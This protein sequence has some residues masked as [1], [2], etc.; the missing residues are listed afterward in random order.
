VGEKRSR[1]F[2]FQNPINKKAHLL[3]QMSFFVNG[4]TDVLIIGPVVIHARYG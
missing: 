4:V 2:S 1:I 3:S